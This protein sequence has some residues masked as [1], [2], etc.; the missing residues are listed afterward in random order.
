VRQLRYHGRSDQQAG[1]TLGFF[2]RIRTSTRCS[3]PN[4]WID[5]LL[6]SCFCNLYD[7]RC[8]QFTMKSC[9]GASTS[10]LAARSLRPN[11]GDASYAKPANRRTNLPYMFYVRTCWSRDVPR[12]SY[13][14]IHKPYESL[15]PHI[16]R[17][18]GMRI[19]RI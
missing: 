12:R 19:N 2:Y 14:S 7:R 16:S 17:K 11:N 18:A 5:A 8:V 13:P 9:S 4:D 3:G 10:P 6:Y 15:V 1:T